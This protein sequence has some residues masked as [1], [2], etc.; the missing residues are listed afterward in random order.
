MKKLILMTIALTVSLAF[1]SCAGDS[2]TPEEKKLANDLYELIMKERERVIH[3]QEIVDI[4][5]AKMNVR[6]LNNHKEKLDSLKKEH[7][8]VKLK[9]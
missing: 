3:W 1:T 6:F 7:D 5:D 8:K 9:L 4:N 2:R